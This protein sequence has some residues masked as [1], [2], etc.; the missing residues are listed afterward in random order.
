M[1]SERLILYKFLMWITLFTNFFSLLRLLFFTL[2]TQL[3]LFIK[4]LMFGLLLLYT[5]NISW[6]YLIQYKSYV[7]IFIAW[8]IPA[9]KFI[10]LP[11]TILQQILQA[12]GAWS[13]LM[14]SVWWGTFSLTHQVWLWL[15]LAGL[16]WHHWQRQSLS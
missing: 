12:L 4:K 7:I 15:R 3:I 9:L 8:T 11:Q 13:V 10:Y 2:M 14:H 1:A 16:L 6:E 5:K